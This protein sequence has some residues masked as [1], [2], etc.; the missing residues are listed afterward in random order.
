[1]GIEELENEL[2]NLK[3]FAYDLDR[4]YAELTKRIDAV[5]NEIKKIKEAEKEE[6]VEIQE[7]P[8][9]AVEENTEVVEA[10]VEEVVPVEE[11]TEVVEAPVEEV[12]PVEENT[13]VVEVPVEET[14]A[15]LIPVVEVPTEE[16]APV[17]ENVEVPV[18]ETS[19]PLIPIVEA[20]V[21]ENTEVVNSDV[22]STQ[23]LEQTPLTPVGIEL[24]SE[25]TPVEKPEEETKEDEHYLVNNEALVGINLPQIEKIDTSAPRAIMINE[26]QAIKLGKSIETQE[27]LALGSENAP[28]EVVVEAA[29]EQPTENTEV[30]P[31]ESK[32]DLQNQI[33]AMMEQLGQAK[34]EEEANDINNKISELNEKYK[35]LAKA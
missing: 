7:D 12:A 29:S 2:N 15:P 1:M 4:Q 16:V 17:A 18:E 3:A 21:E 14:S 10:P 34:S 32:E 8:V 23:P 35:V 25:D 20:P 22:V 19:A 11:N 26:A 30:I 6:V 24:P 13:E 9:V 33:N 27:R 31:T 28:S 5:T